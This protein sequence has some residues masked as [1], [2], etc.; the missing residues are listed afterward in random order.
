M[1]DDGFLIG[2][3]DSSGNFVEVGRFNNVTDDV[4]Q[5]LEIKH[6][7]SGER[8]T[9]DGSGLKM[10]KIDNDRLYAGAFSGPDADARLTNAINTSS[11]G[12]VI[13]LESESYSANRTISKQLI[14]RGTSSVFF[15]GTQMFGN[16]DINGSCKL[17]QIF[18]EGANID[19]NKSNSSLSDSVLR[20]TSVV[21]T[22]NKCKFE[23]LRGTGGAGGGSITF[24]SG[25]AR[26]I[27]DSSIEIQVTDNGVN[28]VGDIA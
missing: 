5:P 3:E 18:F 1:V 9:L 8:I 12:N 22:D 17:E 14:F 23:M 21:V 25:T 6:Q 26:S 16:Y 4:T 11:D 7:N 15:S 10:Q 20:N 27:V 24:Q 19:F 13:Y 28:T 2:F